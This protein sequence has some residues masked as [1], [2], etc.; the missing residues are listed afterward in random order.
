MIKL[1][2]C[3]LL[4]VPA[5]G[6]NLTKATPYSGGIFMADL[7]PLSV[8]NN[9]FKKYYRALSPSRLVIG[10]SPYLGLELVEKLDQKIVGF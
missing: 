8:S 4:E 9:I 5:L 1:G 10:L 7:N 3:I 2:S 6:V